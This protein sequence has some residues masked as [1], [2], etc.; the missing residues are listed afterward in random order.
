MEKAFVKSF[1]QVEPINLSAAGLCKCQV[2]FG[3]K[4]L[5]CSFQ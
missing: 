1:F 4:Q 2:A 5:V 3:T